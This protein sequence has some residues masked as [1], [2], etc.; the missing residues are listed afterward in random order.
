MERSRTSDQAIRITDV[1]KQFNGFLAVDDVSLTVQRGEIMGLLGPNGAG[2]STLTNMVYGLLTPDEGTISILGND[3]FRER[4][5][6]KLLLGA[7]PQDIVLYPYMTVIENIKFFGVMNGF[8]GAALEERIDEMVAY[9]GLDEDA[10]NRN[11]VHLSGGMKRRVN[12]ACGILHDPE[13]VLLD[14]PTA[15][16]DPQNRFEFWKLIR[17]MNEEGK[18]VVLTTHMM[19]EA[20]ELC[21]R[22]AI[23]D[24]GKIVALDTP[25]ALIDS[26]DVQEAVR[27][28][29]QESTPE[30][31][32]I[33]ELIDGVQEVIQEVDPETHELKF[34][35]LVGGANEALSSIVSA[36]M[37]A[38]VKVKSIEIIEPT[39]AEVFL[40]IT[41]RSILEA[42]M[43]MEQTALAEEAV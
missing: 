6:A 41:G 42:E 25:R 29:L 32:A 9:M 23:M 24:K 5:K 31:A 13:I 28:V 26:V 3:V 37:N 1:T 30:H 7:V 8:V 43:E 14:E 18:T 20:Q 21:D 40:E 33:F 38:G 17:R 27:V 34:R 12:T 10:L 15:G 16:L 2:K 11:T 4:N 35:V 39:L 36:T 22:V 19:D